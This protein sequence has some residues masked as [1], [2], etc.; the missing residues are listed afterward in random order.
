M[1]TDNQL[2][3]LQNELLDIY[4]KIEIELI[5]S[6]AK[7]LSNYS[8][9]DGTLEWQI[10]KLS[11]LNVLSK[12]L[13]KIFEKYSNKSEKAVQD[14]LK[15]AM[16]GNVDRDYLNEAFE[17]GVAFI[18]YDSLSKSEV[19]KKM[20][21]SS[22]YDLNNNLSLINTTALE[23]AKSSYTKIL[24]KAYVESATGTYSLN[25]AVQ[26]GIKD[27]AKKG[28]KG[29]T[30][31]SG[32]QIGIEPAVRRDTLSAIINNVNK[33]AIESAN[34]T[35][36]NYVEVSQHLGA[37]TS[38]KSKIANH[39]GWQGKVYQID[40]SSEEYGNLVEE[41]GYGDIEGLG[42]VN[43]RHRMFPYFP[44]ISVKKKVKVDKER[45]KEVY[46]ATQRLRALEREFRANKR[47]W[48]ASKETLDNATQKKCESKSKEILEEIKSIE[49]KYTEI[50]SNSSRTLILEDLK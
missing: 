1:L 36:T 5:L 17:K 48:Y 27:M 10:R 14:M 18:N 21:D 47:M 23:S 32:R 8:T 49:K 4:N 31:E 3:A 45:N 30:Y 35:G 25:E 43:C 42:G 44:G 37:R 2:S 16:L 11:E 6:V 40:G 9:V 39:A 15:K 33:S 22:V 28:F 7:R 20:L 24:N 13:L 46:A 34:L 26:K 41:T 29:A 19:F 38:K 50:G 12:D